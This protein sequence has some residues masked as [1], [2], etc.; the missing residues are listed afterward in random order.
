MKKQLAILILLGFC[1]SAYAGSPIL[2]NSYRFAA[3]TAT[4]SPTETPTPTP[5]GGP[6]LVQQKIGT[7]ASGDLTITLDTDTTPGNVLTVCV[8]Y[9]N[10]DDISTISTI[11]NTDSFVSQASVGSAAIAT[12]LWSLTAV[13][14]DSGIMIHPVTGIT[15]ITA[16]VQE[17]S[18][19]SSS[20]A[21][22]AH[23]DSSG[24]FNST[25]LAGVDIP[26][27]ANNLAIACGG[28][29]ADDYSSGPTDSYVR[30]T[31]AGA[32]SIYL[33]SAY[34]IQF[35][36]DPTSTTWSLSAGINWAAVTAVFGVTTP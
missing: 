36:A 25:V 7:T 31:P 13:R 17:W 12:G 34:L 27:S 6:Q 4:P 23:F 21:E 29:V 5:S 10:S 26:S 3:A 28:W 15:R 2:I 33:E 14:S 18:G 22:D 11:E 32:G 24:S 20:T 8:A 35:S 30:L 9:N 19:L 1:A 16:N